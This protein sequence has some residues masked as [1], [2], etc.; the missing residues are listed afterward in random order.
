MLGDPMHSTLVRAFVHCIVDDLL[1]DSE[2]VEKYPR[3]TACGIDQA[4]VC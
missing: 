2:L 1:L 4:N 3:H